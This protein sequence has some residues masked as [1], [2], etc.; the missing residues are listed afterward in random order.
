MYDIAIIWTDEQHGDIATT[1]NDLLT[2]GGLESAALI[3]LFTDRLAETDD[4][5]PANDGDRRGWWGDIIPA[6]TGDLTGSRLWLL[7]REKQLPEV[8]ARAHE[9]A[10]E[11]L[12]WMLDD[13]IAQRVIV[14]VTN[15]RFQEIDIDVTIYRPGS[16]NPVNF[17]Y[18]YAWQAQAAKITQ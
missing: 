18:N 13:K 8:L 5:L 4:A 17:R 9:Y 1:A 14:S 11:A 12:Q 15:T 2:D 16:N 7:E 6:A 3:S 10:V